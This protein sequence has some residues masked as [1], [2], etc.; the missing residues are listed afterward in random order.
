MTDVTLPAPAPARTRRRGSTLLSDTW[1]IARR[2][3]VHMRRQPE[4]LADATIQ[5]IM[6]VVLFAY[7][8]GGAIEVPGGGDYKEFLMGGIFAQTI[9]F[10][11]FGV[12]IALAHDRT[13]GA[14]DRFHSLPIARAAVLGGHSVANLI[15]AFLPITLMSITGLIIGWRINSSFTDALAGYG[16]MVLFSFAMIW[17]GV[18]LGSVL[19]TPEGVQGVAFVALFP[20]TFIATTFVPVESLATPLKQIAEWN[21][22]SSLSNA[23]R[24]LFGNPGGTAPPDAPWSLQHPILY[25][26]LW[27]VGI[28]VVCAPLAIRAYRRSIAA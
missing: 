20:I 14:I 17:V 13:N 15:R 27:A 10:G 19:A 4:A 7:V 8:F 5:P 9:V 28:V 3:L 25:T 1:V 11:A 23:L 18:L 12:A 24:D 6:F 21:P 26:V 16:L 2:G 22:V